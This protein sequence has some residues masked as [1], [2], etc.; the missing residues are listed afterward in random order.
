[1]DIVSHSFTCL[2]LG[3]FHY[4]FCISENRYENQSLIF[5]AGIIMIIGVEPHGHS[6]W[7]A[8]PFRTALERD[9]ATHSHRPTQPTKTALVKARSTVYPGANR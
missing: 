8:S 6:F 3:R 5:Q 7:Q 2:D 1:M 4:V 9:R